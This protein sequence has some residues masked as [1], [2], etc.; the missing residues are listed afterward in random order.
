MAASLHRITLIVKIWKVIA[1]TYRDAGP[2]LKHHF[3]VAITDQTQAVEALRIRRAE[4][5]MN[6]LELF[7]RLPW[8]DDDRLPRTCFVSHA[9][10]DEG[11][12]L[13][14]KAR[15]PPHV[16]PVYFQPLEFVLTKELATI[17]FEASIVVVV[18]FFSKVATP[19]H[20]RGCRSTGLR[21]SRS[22]ESLWV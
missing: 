5:D 9:Y 7:S 19:R 13:K 21:T 18:L 15:L 22:K 11:A 12:G 3:F 2:P 14:L 1:I 16:A 6:M 10:K 20:H 17:S 8:R 4:A